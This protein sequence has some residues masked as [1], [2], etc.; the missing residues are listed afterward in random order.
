MGSFT[1]FAENEVLDQLFGAQ[2]YT[3]P[4]TLYFGLSTSTVAD[5]GSNITE[6]SGN[7]YSRVAVTNNKTNF[8][9]SS[10]GSVQNDAAISFPQASGSWGTITDFFISDASSGGNILAYGALDAS[11]AVGDGDTLSFAIGDLTITLA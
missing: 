6:P 5:D 1:D 11:K 2:A 3:A 10:G 7:N 4:A 9:V 8:S